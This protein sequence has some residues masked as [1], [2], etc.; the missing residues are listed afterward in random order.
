MSSI[1]SLIRNTV[2]ALA[3]LGLAAGSAAVYQ[4]SAVVFAGG[5][6]HPGEYDA[7]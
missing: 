6:G 5:S 4:P 2:L 7:G 1:K 3:I